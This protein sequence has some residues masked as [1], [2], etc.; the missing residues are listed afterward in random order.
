LSGLQ[1]ISPFQ[2]QTKAWSYGPGFFTR[3]FAQVPA[4]DPIASPEFI[5]PTF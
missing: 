1:E 3:W 4:L 2:G 5:Q